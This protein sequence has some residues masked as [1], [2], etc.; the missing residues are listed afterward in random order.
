MEQIVSSEQ[1]LE[2]IKLEPILLLGPKIKKRS[3]NFTSLKSEVVGEEEGEHRAA[4][5]KGEEAA[6]MSRHVGVQGKSHEAAQ[7][8]EQI[9]KAGPL[10]NGPLKNK[11]A[12][13]PTLLR[14]SRSQ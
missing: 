7:G 9:N 13:G 14:H 6:L 5:K 3:G 11:I 8:E 1:I 12:S 10:T 4:L 2:F